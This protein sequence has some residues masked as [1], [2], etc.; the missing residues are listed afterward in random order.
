MTDPS[1]IA[2]HG[3]RYVFVRPAPAQLEHLSGLVDD[4]VVQIPVSGRFPL[5]DAAAAH[6]RLDQRHVRGKL[7]LEVV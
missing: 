3:G 5:A 1:A 4:G 7:V 6:E 2:A